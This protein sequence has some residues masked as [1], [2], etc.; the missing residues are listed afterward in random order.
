MAQPRKTVTGLREGGRGG[1]AV[2]LDGERWRTLPLGVAAEARLS[3]GVELD[4]PRARALARALRQQQALETAARA[5]RRRDLPAKALDLRLERAGV[6]NATRAEAMETLARS[7]LVDDERYA[8]ARATAL[9]GRGYG[10]AAIRWDLERQGVESDLVERA[11]DELEPELERAQRLVS[12][13]G[14][15][16]STAR[17]LARRGFGEDAVERA[18]GAEP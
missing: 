6:A 13:R 9:A 5:L 18:G 8:H 7:R 14:R 4:R 16:P 17:Q 10:D 2:E 11:L 1:V 12:R 15:S 3:P